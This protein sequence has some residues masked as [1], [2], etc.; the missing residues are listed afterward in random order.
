[1]S[2]WTATW[3]CLKYSIRMYV[4]NSFIL[5]SM[6]MTAWL[7]LLL[8]L[9][10]LMRMMSLE[11]LKSTFVY[12]EEQLLFAVVCMNLY[13]ETVHKINTA[14]ILEIFLICIFT[15]HENFLLRYG[16]YGRSNRIVGK[17]KFR[18]KLKY[19]YRLIEL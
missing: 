13:V 12:I 17:T 16:R 4:L 18:S 8:L 9:L 14:H 7:L 3:S 1:M 6:T 15:V 10:L 5:S 11:R 2:T 19:W